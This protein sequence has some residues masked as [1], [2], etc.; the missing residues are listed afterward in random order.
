[1][2]DI[3]LRYFSNNENFPFFIQYGYHKEEM[4][5]HTHADFSELVVILEGSATHIVNG[6]E[7]PIQKGDVFVINDS[8]SHGYRHTNN[9][10]LCNIM[11][12]PSYFLPVQNDLKAL[13]GFHALFV[14]EPALSKQKGFLGQFTLNRRNFIEIQQLIKQI[15]DEFSAQSSGYQTMITSLF[16]QMI[17]R[18][19]RFYHTKSPD[20]ENDSLSLAAPAAYIESHFREEITI[21]QLSRMANMSTRHFRRIFHGIYGTSPLKYINNLRIQAAS[22][23][24]T[25]SK[26]SVTEIAIRCGYSDGNYFSSKFKQATGKSPM[27]YRK[28][29]HPLTDNTKSVQ[30]VKNL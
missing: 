12:Q 22:H 4:F 27:E 19:S 3:F 13:P 14:I 8:T 23:L 25:N 20:M 21:D 6:E 9:F 11:F 16:L 24:L 15:S 17:T 10:R 5:V 2:Q 28:Y 18:L 29:I 7:Y 26:L 1:M 30:N